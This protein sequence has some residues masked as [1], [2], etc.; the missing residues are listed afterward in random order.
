MSVKV[1]TNKLFKI[2]DDNADYI[3]WGMATAGLFGSLYFSEVQKLPPC[4]LCWYQ[5]ILMY[6]LVAMFAVSIL[7]KDRHVAY[8]GLPLVAIGTIIAFYHSLLQWGI[9]KEDL[10]NCSVNSAVSCAKV[11]INWLGFITIP[12]L[13]FLAFALM[14]ALLV[15]RI[16]LLR[17]KFG[18]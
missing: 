13:S 7:R 4:T 9:V 6:P 16:Y 17:Q 15:Y 10:I 1:N 8:Y 18:K 11:Q 12:F 14:T 3:I 5:R 2:I